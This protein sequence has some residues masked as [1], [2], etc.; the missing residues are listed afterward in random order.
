MSLF[1]DPKEAIL[2]IRHWQ[3]LYGITTATKTDD[4]EPP[5]RQPFTVA[6]TLE[7]LSSFCERRQPGDRWVIHNADEGWQDPVVRIGLARN[8]RTGELALNLVVDTFLST[9]DDE[10]DYDDE[11]EEEVTPDRSWQ[12]KGF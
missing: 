6:E 5:H 7:F 8:R 10:E 12:G 2:T 3:R 11:P 9:H 1:V 4:D